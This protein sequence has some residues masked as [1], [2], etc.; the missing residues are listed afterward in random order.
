MRKLLACVVALAL[1]L[2]AALF[3]TVA[4]AE[5]GHAVVRL[6]VK[7]QIEGKAPAVLEEY[8]FAL[9][10][11]D[12]APMPETTVAKVV[13]EGTAS[14]PEIVFAAPGTYRY[15]V[16]EIAGETE[17]C[18][19][20][21]TVYDVTVQV[22]SDGEGNLSGVVWASKRGEGGKASDIIFVNRYDDP[23][24]SALSEE[25]SGHLVETGDVDI[26]PIAALALLAVVSFST[27]IVLAVRWGK[28]SRSTSGD[29]S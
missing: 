1:T 18:T 12:G 10:P 16:S 24:D 2:G 23:G 29:N 7:K 4:Y 6:E 13:G 20:D 9:E 21:S 25:K 3:S 26:A 28:D 5:S 22:V 14:F 17:E 8:G 15:A 11:I 27:C 19:Y